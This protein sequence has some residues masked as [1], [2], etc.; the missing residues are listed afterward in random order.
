MSNNVILQLKK[1]LVWHRF[2]RFLRKSYAPVSLKMPSQRRLSIFSSSTSRSPKLF[3]KADF[4]KKHVSHVTCHMSHV[5]CHMS[6]VICHIYL[7]LRTKWFRVL[8]HFYLINTAWV[9]FSSDLKMDPL[10]LYP[11]MTESAQWGQK[12]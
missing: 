3:P 4:L 12:I 7:F 11:T 10:N 2:G 9:V 8:V 1:A 5:K 6:H